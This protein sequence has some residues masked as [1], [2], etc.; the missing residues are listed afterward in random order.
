MCK[1]VIV[2]F[3]FFLLLKELSVILYISFLS[4]TTNNYRSK[5][6]NFNQPNIMLE[7]FLHTLLFS[8]TCSSCLYSLDHALSSGVGKN[9]PFDY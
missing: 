2:S 6:H 8:D 9:A 5:E 1:T 3:S 7:Q 4:C